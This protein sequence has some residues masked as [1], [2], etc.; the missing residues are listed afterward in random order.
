MTSE[1]VDQD[2]YMS[3]CTSLI[4]TSGVDLFINHDAATSVRDD[5]VDDMTANETTGY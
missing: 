2:D 4:C 3:Q 1:V 5:Y